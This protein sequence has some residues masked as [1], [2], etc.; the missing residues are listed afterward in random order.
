MAMYLCSISFTKFK[1]IF[2]TYLWVWI[3]IIYTLLCARGK[4]KYTH[5][6]YWWTN[7]DICIC[8]PRA[9]RLHIWIQNIDNIKVFN[10]LKK[11]SR[12]T[13]LP[14]DTVRSLFDTIS[15]TWKYVAH[16]HGFVLGKAQYGTLQR[17]RV[18]VR[19]NIR[20]KIEGW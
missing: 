4:S 7:Y 17:L 19:S 18:S 15:Y 20:H 12:G 11:C 13:T 2:N 14:L 8:I 16:M 3:L 10:S 6:W 5:T 1:F 9:L